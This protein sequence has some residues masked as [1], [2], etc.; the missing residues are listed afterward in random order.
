MVCDFTNRSSVCLPESFV[1]QSEVHIGGNMKQLKGTKIINTIIRNVYNKNNNTHSGHNT[2]SMTHEHA[3][4]VSLLYSVKGS[5]AEQ[6]KETRW[7]HSC[8]FNVNT[9]THT[10]SSCLLLP[11]HNL[12]PID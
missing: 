6:C 9:H 11:Y 10:Q 1:W 5:E 12:P 7:L 3:A 8:P 2:H 4:G